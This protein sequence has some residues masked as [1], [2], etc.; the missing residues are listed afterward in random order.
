MIKFIVNFLP[1]HGIFCTYRKAPPL[2][3][4]TAQFRRGPTEPLLV[5]RDIVYTFLAARAFTKKIYLI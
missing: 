4:A 1:I 2:S 5:L 3:C